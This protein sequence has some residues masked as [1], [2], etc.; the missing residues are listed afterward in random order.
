MK[1]LINI[2]KWWGIG[3]IISIII[4]LLILLMFMNFIYVIIISFIFG[5]GIIGMF[6]FMMYL[7]F[8]DT[9][10][11]MKLCRTRNTQLFK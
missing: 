4:S 1:T 2:L 11:D 5:S 7:T 6:A 10:E 3:C 9:K 8:Q